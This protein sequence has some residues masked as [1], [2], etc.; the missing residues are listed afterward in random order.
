MIFGQSV[1]DWYKINLL[2]LLFVIG[3]DIECTVGYL[4]GEGERLFN[5]QAKQ[6]YFKTRPFVMSSDCPTF[7]QFI[8]AFTDRH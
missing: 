3:P 2:A 5:D 8:T 6:C 1:R 7:P 4:M